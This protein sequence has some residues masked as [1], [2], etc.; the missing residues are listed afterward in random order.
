MRTHNYFVVTDFH[1]VRVSDKTLKRFR[2]MHAGKRR[3]EAAVMK[4]AS[5]AIEAVATW[6]SEKAW[7]A[8]KDL[9]VI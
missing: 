1:T 5:I 3:S 9:S 4:R 6:E 2:D 7:R 8:G